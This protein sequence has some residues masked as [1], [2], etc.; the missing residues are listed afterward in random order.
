[1]LNQSQQAAI[2]FDKLQSALAYCSVWDKCVPELIKIL[3]HYKE[4]ITCPPMDTH[5]TM[6]V[7]VVGVLL[8]H[9]KA[10]GYEREI[11]P[12][13]HERINV[14]QDLKDYAHMMRKVSHGCADMNCSLCDKE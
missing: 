7:D 4:E 12:E 10:K 3:E 11:L 2:V 1:M 14:L 5:D 6:I 13:P 9:L 8:L